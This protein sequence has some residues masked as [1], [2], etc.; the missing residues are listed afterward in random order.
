MIPMKDIVEAIEFLPAFNQTAMKALQLIRGGNYN[1]RD[2]SEVIK[3]D[4]GLSANILKA[5]N[6]AY[7]AKSKDIHDIQA[8]VSYLGRDYLL[9][10]LN[11]ISTRDYYSSQMM[12]YE[13]K[14]GELWEH[15]LSVAVFAEALAGKE[16]GIDKD[17]LFSAGLLHDIGKI[18]LNL[19][20]EKEWGK[21]VHLVEVEKKDF[22]A[23]EKEVLGYTHAMIGGAILKKWNFPEP[24]ILAAKHHH[25]LKLYDNPV[26]RIVCLADYLTFLVGFMSQRDNMNLKGYDQVL[27]YYQIQT[28]EID[29]LISHSFDKINQMINE[30]KIS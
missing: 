25:D 23:A 14:G 27:E 12:G 21:I 22:I 15:N 13:S 11:L 6:S 16:P 4:A 20:V 5:V 8:A 7:F 26:V 10:L 9:F 1:A 28:K 3:L 30:F 2:L 29:Q 24:I 17:L 19:W 18:I